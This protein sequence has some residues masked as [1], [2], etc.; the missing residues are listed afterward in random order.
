MQKESSK[1][2]LLQPV[3]PESKIDRPVDVYKTQSLPLRS[4][5]QNKQTDFCH[6]KGGVFQCAVCEGPEVL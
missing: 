3:F 6:T 1:T 4:K 5:F 2:G